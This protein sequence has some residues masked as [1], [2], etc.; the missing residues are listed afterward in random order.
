M[1][2]TFLMVIGEPT[3]KAPALQDQ[4]T[5]RVDKIFN[6]IYQHHGSVYLQT[7]EKQ[8]KSGRTISNLLIEALNNLD[9]ERQVHC[10]LSARDYLT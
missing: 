6:T 9:A 3:N 4:L 1:P 10:A 5:P 8:S 7:S 2:S